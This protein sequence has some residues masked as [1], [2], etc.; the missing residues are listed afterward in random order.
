MLYHI[1]VFGV[2]YISAFFG[3]GNGGDVS[4]LI[5]AESIMATV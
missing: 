2:L 3:A 5:D 4:H 1:M